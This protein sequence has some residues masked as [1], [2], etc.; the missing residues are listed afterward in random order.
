MKSIAISKK[1]LAIAFYAGFIFNLSSCSGLYNSDKI[2]GDF[3]IVDKSLN[4]PEGWSSNVFVKNNSGNIKIDETNY[5][6]GNYSVLMEIPNSS[7]AG[8]YDY[9][10]VRKIAG[11]ENGGMYELNGWIKT[12]AT[13]N[14]PYIKIEFWSGEHLCGNVKAGNADLNGAKNWTEVNSIFKVPDNTTKIFISLILP[15]ANNHGG[16][17]WFDNITITALNR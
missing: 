8:K 1:I 9:K 7:R 12:K 11:L 2:N 15:T 13:K 4:C 5:K 3:E 14:P 17:A 6:S 10:L 16:K